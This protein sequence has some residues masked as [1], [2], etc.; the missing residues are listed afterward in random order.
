MGCES[1]VKRALTAKFTCA[2]EGEGTTAGGACNVIAPPGTVDGAA[3]GPA[4]GA[5][6]CGGAENPP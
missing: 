6:C 2:V 5:N 1:R 3:E 4:A